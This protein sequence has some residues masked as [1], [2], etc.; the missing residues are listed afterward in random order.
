MVKLKIYWLRDQFII[1]FFFIQDDAVLIP[2]FTTPSVSHGPDRFNRKQ[3]REF[4]ATTPRFLAYDP[5]HGLMNRGTGFSACSGSIK[6]RAEQRQG[7]EQRGKNREKK[8]SDEGDWIKN[9]EQ[10]LKQNPE[11]GDPKT[12]QPIAPSSNQPRNRTTHSTRQQSNPE[13]QSTQNTKK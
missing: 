2:L 5:A 7:E 13:I 8:H 4:K 11:G 12:E 3:I 1:C 9:R 6:G 10:R